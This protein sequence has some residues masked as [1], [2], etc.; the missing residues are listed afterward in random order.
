[1]SD[2]LFEENLY[3]LETESWKQFCL[4]VKKHYPGFFIK[5]EKYC[6]KNVTE[7]SFS[8]FLPRFFPP[9]M[10]EISDEH[11]ECFHQKIKQMENRYQGRISKNMLADYCWFLHRES[12]TI[13]MRQ[14]KR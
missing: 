12:D 5:L 8:P 7:N 9:N 3:P 14:A 10:G 11:D 4:V 6:G 1:M 13:Y 2:K